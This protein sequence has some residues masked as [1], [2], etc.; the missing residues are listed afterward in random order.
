MALFNRLRCQ[1]VST[2]YLNVEGDHF[3]ASSMHWGSFYI[4]LGKLDFVSSVCVCVCLCVCVC[5]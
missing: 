3:Q 4:H 5:V 2:R 1:T